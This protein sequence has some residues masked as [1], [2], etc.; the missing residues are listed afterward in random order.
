M[1]VDKMSLSSTQSIEK[2]DDIGSTNE[3]YGRLC[4][5]AVD[6]N[7]NSRCFTKTRWFDSEA[8]SAEF[9]RTLSSSAKST[10]APGKTYWICGRCRLAT[11]DKKHQFS[12]INKHTLYCCND[13]IKQHKLEI[14][15][16][17]IFRQIQFHLGF[18]TLWIPSPD[19]VFLG[20]KSQHHGKW[21][22]LVVFLVVTL[23]FE[24][25]SFVNVVIVRALAE[26]MRIQRKRPV[27]DFGLEGSCAIC[28]VIII[29]VM[30]HDGVLKYGSN[31]WNGELIGLLS[32]ACLMLFSYV[33]TS[34][35]AFRN[36]IR[37][38]VT[39][40]EGSPNPFGEKKKF[41]LLGAIAYLS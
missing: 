1:S 26:K 37:T 32:C 41:D 28:W 12:K 7:S 25:A 2:T 30:T 6:I 8:E 36:L 15:L 5:P 19:G 20:D 17:M 23:L 22:F 9:N 14:I 33:F 31:G 21:V 10:L 35:V 38:D 40:I 3:S 11:T 34:C 18:T 39:V 24:I 29:A 27:I 4:G 13:C 16:G